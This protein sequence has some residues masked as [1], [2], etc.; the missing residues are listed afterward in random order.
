VKLKPARAAL[1][2]VKVGE[3]A[4]GEVQGPGSRK[5]AATKEAASQLQGIEHVCENVGTVVF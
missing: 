5:F 2:Y 3:V 1:D 4:G